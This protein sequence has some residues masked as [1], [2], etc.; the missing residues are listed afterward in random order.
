M[1]RLVADIDLCE[2]GSLYWQ[3][4]QRYAPSGILKMSVNGVSM[5]LGLAYFVIEASRKF[6][7]A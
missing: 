3:K 6:S 7:R 4:Q 2:I 1:F 5:V